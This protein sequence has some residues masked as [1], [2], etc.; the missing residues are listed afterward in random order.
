[1][2][3]PHPA[4]R[5][6]W[7][8]AS[9]A[10]YALG[11]I[12]K[13]EERW[14]WLLRSSSDHLILNE[15]N[16]LRSLTEFP[17][18][19]ERLAEVLNESLNETVASSI[20]DKQDVE[21]EPRP[22]ALAQP[23]RVGSENLGRAK[24]AELAFQIAAESVESEAAADERGLSRS[25]KPLEQI[26]P[27]ARGPERALVRG[28]FS[29]TRADARDYFAAMSDRAGMRAEWDTL[30]IANSDSELS[31]APH[32]DLRRLW[33][34]AS[35]AGYFMR[36]LR[37][38]EEGWVS[39]LGSSSD[40]L[41]F[42]EE[43][44]VRPL[45]GLLGIDESLAGVLA[46]SIMEGRQDADTAA[47]PAGPAQGLKTGSLRSGSAKGVSP[48]R[49]AAKSSVE[50]N[51]VAEPQIKARKRESSVSTTSGKG[52]HR[53]PSEAEQRP[54]REKFSI[55]RADARDHFE[56]ISDQLG[57]RS[58]WDKP[59][60]ATSGNGQT[61]DVPGL[62]SEV[63]AGADPHPFNSEYAIPHVKRN[64][65]Q[66]TASAAS[67]RE[68]GSPAV[69][70]NWGN[71]REGAD[72]SSPG[73]VDLEAAATGAAASDVRLDQILKRLAERTIH[74]PRNSSRRKLTSREVR[75]NSFRR[76]QMDEVDLAPA[77]HL[78]PEVPLSGLQ[79]LAQRAVNAGQESAVESDRPSANEDRWRTS[80]S[81]EL[82]NVL[83]AAGGESAEFGLQ[84]AEFLRREVLRQ[85]ISLEGL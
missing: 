65:H 50:S 2:V 58:S 7:I 33:I 27:P 22:P 45:L 73:S 34:D 68:I 23:L 21:S 10:G 39:L 19:D 63:G 4:L 71:R 11:Q 57:V 18:I 83:P 13:L 79:R 64:N 49:R 59:V 74:S 14:S 6:F 16:W 38:L 15:E 46:R 40:L 24:R 81:P 51:S 35:S 41:I 31:E 47:M 30:V 44:V 48:L 77:V 42:H 29:I 26:H 20:E 76:S 25:S 43:D 82:A 12:R 85:G 62:V 72:A 28:K 84:L 70:P 52:I 56:K 36:Q 60:S 32:A 78:T 5:G 8:E 37:E 9:G 17:D 69:P 80:G 61:L 54:V 3:G 53:S 75:G 66:R 1:M 55:T 67:F